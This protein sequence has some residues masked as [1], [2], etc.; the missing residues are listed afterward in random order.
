MDTP[1]EIFTQTLLA[2]E[3]YTLFRNQMVVQPGEVT[4]AQLLAALSRAD[5]V[6]GLL[7]GLRGLQWGGP[8]RPTC[9][10]WQCETCKKTFEV[11]GCVPYEQCP[12]CRRRLR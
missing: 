5:K 7:A 12:H 6:I 3:E 4:A 1:D 9:T 8:L 10:A 11:R 2:A